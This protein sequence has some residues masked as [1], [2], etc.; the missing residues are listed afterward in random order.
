M[1][2]QLVLTTQVRNGR[3]SLQKNFTSPPLKLISLPPDA[4]GMLRVVQMSSSPGLLGGDLIEISITLAAYSHLS[5]YTQAFTR[6]LEM[7]DGKQAEQH[8]H[9][10]QE[11]HSHLCYLPHPLVLHANSTFIQYTE[12]ELDDDCGLVYGEIIAAGRVLRGERFAFKRFSSHLCITYHGHKL[13]TDNIQ[14]Y[15]ERYQIDTIGQMEQYTHQLNLFYVHTAL[16]PEE[17]R[18]LNERIFEKLDEYTAEM[19]SLLWGVSQAAGCALCLRALS[20]EAQSLQ[21][22]LKVTVTILQ[23]SQA[24]PL[25]AVFFK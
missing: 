25:S 16:S 14:W 15:P 18:V 2:S 19:N 23:Q 20:T 10:R 1:Y 4:N 21:N 11:P 22:L 12:I 8:T 3:T 9:I 24:S 5:L 7:N 6:V 13:I 17:I